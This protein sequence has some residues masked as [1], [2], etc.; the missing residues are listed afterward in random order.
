[1]S[2]HRW[3]DDPRDEIRRR[4]DIVDLVGREVPLKKRGKNWLG[5]CP[6]HADKNP[7]FTVSPETGRYKCFACGAGG[8]VFTWV[9]ER[10]NIEFPEA[11]QLLAREAN[12]ILP[13]RTGPREP[14]VDHSS[15]METALAYFREQFERSSVAREYVAGRQMDDATVKTWEIGYAP[16]VGEAL[17]MYLKKAGVSLAVSKEAFLIDE[18]ASGGYFDKFRGRLMFPIR[19]ERGQ[20]VAFGGRLLTAGHPKYINSGDTPIYR[21]SRVLYGLNRAREPLGKSRR[22]VLCEGYLDVIA[23][24]RA[25]VDTAVASLGTALAEDQA[26]LLKRWSDEV[27]I[28]YDSDDAGRKAALR[29]TDVLQ[30]AG[31]R[32]RIATM[33]QGDDPDTL[34][35]A[36]GPDAVRRAVEANM[37]PT[38]F[39]LMDVENRL[40]PRQEEF[41]TEVVGILALEEN[42]L[43]IDRQI[44]LLAGKYPDLRDPVS[45]RKALQRMVEAKRGRA[46]P[47]EEEPRAY[48]PRPRPTVA[49]SSLH[50]A[51][52]IV[53]RSL[54][55]ER[56]RRNAWLFSRARDLFTTDLG[57]R[58]SEA[59]A[60]A[61]P[62]APPEG[63]PTGWLHRLGDEPLREA[64]STL[65]DDLRGQ[66]LS[67]DYLAD[68]V[69][70]LREMSAARQQRATL[71]KQNDDSAKVD[72]LAK[73]RLRK[74]DTRIVKDD[75]EDLL[76]E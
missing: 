10:R 19:D 36:G 60:T 32:V 4:V 7:S 35:K 9:M 6:F 29:A 40:N 46:A 69:T 64:L 72:Y 15:A 66:R 68:A 53:F 39:R 2:H 33:P 26:K 30:T 12:V 38:A 58:L 1:M 24:H 59:V 20:L 50:A 61:F 3:V 45:A 5:L 67:E 56:Y 11:L 49:K 21:K 51:E 31:L 73:L 71:D 62:S 16:N 28:L 48:R 17:A 65:A 13:E 14:R 54:L 44:P 25:G 18:D 37:A 63:P 70:K 74:P 52:L 41:W 23:C 42:Q 22:A 76:F 55:D 27:V 75:D 8:D 43:E 57:V 34:L 47:S